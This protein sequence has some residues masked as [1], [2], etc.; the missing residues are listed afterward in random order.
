MLVSE[1]ESGVGPVVAASVVTLCLRIS[2]SLFTNFW[3][4]MDMF[5][6]GKMPSVGNLLIVYPR[7][8]FKTI[9]LA[10]LAHSGQ[11]LK[12]EVRLKFFFIFIDTS[13]IF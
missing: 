11:R 8:I 2:F 5:T 10:A 1:V 9:V 12:D 13:I 3:M 4:A 6:T 7:T